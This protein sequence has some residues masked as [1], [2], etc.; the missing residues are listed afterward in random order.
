MLVA[1]EMHL[2][3][4]CC[5]GALQRDQLGSRCILV[6]GIRDT[7]THTHTHT[8]TRTH[9]AGPNPSSRD[10]PG[11]PAIE[12]PP[13]R[14]GSVSSIS[15]P[16]TKTPHAVE[17]LHSGPTPEPAAWNSAQQRSLR[18]EKPERN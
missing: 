16:G 18:K 7:H 13:A 5:Q 1:L 12:H 3:G 8:H 9:S 11:G 14:A 10:F 15:G 4:H 6:I 17:Q 2:E